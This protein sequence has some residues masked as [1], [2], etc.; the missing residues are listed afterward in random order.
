MEELIDRL[1]DE[2]Y[3]PATSL[4]VA[5]GA[6]I[7]IAEAIPLLNTMRIQGLLRRDDHSE[8]PITQETLLVATKKGLFRANGLE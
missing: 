6:E 7:D 4:E 1:L 2:L 5:E 8:G 3:F